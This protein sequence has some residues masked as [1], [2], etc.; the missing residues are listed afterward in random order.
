MDTINTRLTIVSV[1]SLTFFATGCSSGNDSGPVENG[2]DLSGQEDVQVVTEARFN[3]CNSDQDF[4]DSLLPMDNAWYEGSGGVCVKLCDPENS[5]VT[6]DG[7]GTWAFDETIGQQCL[8]VAAEEAQFGAEVP[9]YDTESLIALDASRVAGQRLYAR[10]DQWVCTRQTRSN[11][12]QTFSA[13][14]DSLLYEFSANGTVSNSNYFPELPASEHILLSAGYW[15]DSFSFDENLGILH[16][17]DNNNP[18]AVSGPVFQGYTVYF[19]ESDD[20]SDSLTIF[21]TSDDKI[22][23]ERIRNSA[24]NVPSISRL[25]FEEVAIADILNVPMTCN[26]YEQTYYSEVLHSGTRLSSL[27]NYPGSPFAATLTET[28]EI[29]LEDSRQNGAEFVA[30]SFEFGNEQRMVSLTD[31]PQYNFVDTYAGLHMLASE[32]Q[33]IARFRNGLSFF[34]GANE[35]DTLRAL[36]NSHSAFYRLPGGEI[37]FEEILADGGNTQFWEQ[38]SLCRTTE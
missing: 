15:V 20:D 37:V 1:I 21:K 23:C 8:N 10:G 26:V 22:A 25:E 6:D 29:T 36:P 38:Y 11:H 34:P 35:G 18:E 17:I 9:I 5:I 27:V 13:E 3:V 19:Y 7:D 30:R 16:S 12:Q 4:S 14:G 28:G 32:T 33:T 24:L 2:S 31:N